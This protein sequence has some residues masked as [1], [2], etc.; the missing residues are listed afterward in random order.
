MRHFKWISLAAV[1]ILGLGA[2]WLLGAGSAAQNPPQ[3]RSAASA[4]PVEVATAAAKPMPVEIGTIGRTQTVASVAVKP[5]IEGVVQTVNVEDGQEVK[6]GDVLFTLDDRAL[7]AALKQ[8]EAALARDRATLENAKRE[9]ERQM[10]LLAKEYVPRA[11]MDQLKTTAAA[12]EAT[13]RA[14]EAALEAARVQLSYA[15]IRAPID[16]RLGTINYKTGNQVRPSDAT[17]LV[18]LNQIAP[19]Y[20]ALSVPQASYAAIQRAMQAGPVTVRAHIPG[21]Q[22]QP[23]EGTVAYIENAIDQASNTLS[24]KAS[25]ANAERRLW[26]G[27]F[28]D[29]TVILSMQADAVTLPAEAVQA[30][31]NGPYLFVVKDG[32]NGGKVVEARDVTVDRRIDGE[33]V[34]G[35]GVSAGETVVVN[36]QLRLANGT[37]VT[38]RQQA[39]PGSPVKAGAPS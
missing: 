25:F 14:D 37:P 30:G 39:S 6:A 35:K 28:V 1:A 32:A 24:L 27:Q 2:W 3:P 21:D 17:P 11:T 4:V 18:T 5:R 38:I 33:V 26:P 19:I 22:G 16:G 29:A 15:T 34:I 20:V 36:G 12:A 13:V 10:P 9:V 7:V 31:Q 8:A 23:I